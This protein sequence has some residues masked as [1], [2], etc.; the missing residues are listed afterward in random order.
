MSEAAVYDMLWKQAVQAARQNTLGTDGWIDNPADDRFGVT[1]L[2]RP[3]ARVTSNIQSFISRLSKT[4]PGQYYYPPADLHVT[5]LTVISCAAGFR[6]NHIRAN[7][8]ISLINDVL[9]R[10]RAFR[11]TFRGCTLTPAGVIV[12]GFAETGALEAIRNDLRMAFKQSVLHHTIDSRYRLQ[13]AHITC[14]RFK[15]TVSDPDKLIGFLEHH[16]DIEFGTQTVTSAQFVF[17]NWYHQRTKVKPIG[18]FTL[19]Q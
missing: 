9:I 15:K 8:Y 18:S 10:H 4:A 2:F 7:D 5:V 11:I 1:L 3:N 14:M 16:R 13:T 17:N 12:M 19:K 6:L